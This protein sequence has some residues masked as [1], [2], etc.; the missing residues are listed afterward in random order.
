MSDP[1]QIDSG[2]VDLVINVLSR[3]V[4]IK[5]LTHVVAAIGRQED[6]WQDFR[7][8]AIG[9][10]SSVLLNIAKGRNMDLIDYLGGL[11]KGP[12]ILPSQVL[13]EF[14]NNQVH[15]V[16]GLADQIRQKFS[17]LEKLVRQIEP[18]Y[19]ELSE[20]L[21]ATLE[22]FRASFGHVLDDQTSLG[23]S[24]L[25]NMFETKGIHPEACR[26]QLAPIAVQRKRAKTPPGFKDEGDGDFLVW[27]DFL[28][29]ILMAKRQGVDY[30]AAILITDDVKKDWSTKGT[31]NPILAAEVMALAGVPFASVTFDRFSKLVRAELQST[32]GQAAPE[33]EAGGVE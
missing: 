28:L 13:Q 7:G 6:A 31:P 32:N 11:H 20:G 25:L 23:I 2:D 22:N 3:Q 27:A 1:R 16:S 21:E 24:S 4:P 29:G 14:W 5:A 26:G 19:K 8:C 18:T 33:D 17:E 9:F 12:L 10:D 30:S 15:A